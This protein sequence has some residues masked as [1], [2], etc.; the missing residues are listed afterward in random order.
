MTCRLLCDMCS[1]VG[2]PTKCTTNFEAYGLALHH[3][4]MSDLVRVASASK[5]FMLFAEEIRWFRLSC[6]RT[7]VGC[8][9][10]AELHLGA[11]S[12]VLRI[13]RHGGPAHKGHTLH[14]RALGWLPGAYGSREVTPDGERPMSIEDLL[15]MRALFAIA[16]D[17]LANLGTG[18]SFHAELTTPS[19][20]TLASA[21]ILPTP[22]ELAA[23]HPLNPPQCHLPVR[24]TY[25]SVASASQT[26]SLLSVRLFNKDGCSLHYAESRQRDLRTVRTMVIVS[27]WLD[28]LRTDGLIVVVSLAMLGSPWRVMKAG[29]LRASGPDWWFSATLLDSA[30]LGVEA[31]LTKDIFFQVVAIQDDS[32]TNRARGG[33]QAVVAPSAIR[34]TA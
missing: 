9:G 29:L 1:G 32:C 3:I 34:V 14:L 17:A 22:R 21:P 28:L 23:S 2:I 19:W 13:L 18:A 25:H 6:A 7:E 20:R 16:D 10:G 31:Q 26:E 4:G 33:E 15:W 12:I 24:C 5:T 11:E 8:T 30:I 27:K